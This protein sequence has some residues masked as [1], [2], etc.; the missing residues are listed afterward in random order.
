[1]MGAGVDNKM[2]LAAHA[3][4]VGMSNAHTLEMWLA[5]GRQ[6]QQLLLEQT[7]QFVCT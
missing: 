4:W 7:L 2:K 1:M 5:L 3:S 6:H